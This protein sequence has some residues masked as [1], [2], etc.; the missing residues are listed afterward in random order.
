MNV[1]FKQSFVRDLRA[2][3]DKDLLR[4]VQD[5]I[6]TVEQANSLDDVP[7]LRK[8]KGQNQYFRIR[9]GDYRLGL[10]LEGDVVAFVRFLHRRDI[11]RYFP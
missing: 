2:V 6:Q 9:V 10:V 7:G 8:L 4:R 11:Y 3:R 1:Q 5:I